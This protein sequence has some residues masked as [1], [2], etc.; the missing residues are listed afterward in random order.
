MITEATPFL[1]FQ[2]NCAKAIA[3]YQRAL[4]ATVCDSRGWDPAMFGG[5]LPP[6][7]EDGVMYARLRIGDVPLEMSDMP[8]GVSAEP[9]SNLCINLHITDPDELDGCFAALAEGGQPLLAPED[10][11]WGARYAQVIDAFGIGWTLHC[12]LT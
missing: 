7:M 8:P 10:M 6:G 3:L 4:G 1:K 11:F 5:Q 2:G 12:M 9:G